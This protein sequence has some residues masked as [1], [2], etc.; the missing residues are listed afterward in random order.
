MSRRE[1]RQFLSRQLLENQRLLGLAGEHP[2]MAPPLRQ[3]VATLQRELEQ[4]PQ[5]EPEARTVLFFGGDPVDGSRGIDAQFAAKVLEPFLE[6]VKTEYAVERHGWV[7]ARGVRRDEAQAR[8]MLTGL[9]RGSFGLE[10]TGPAPG[11]LFAT[12]ELSDVL[13]RITDLLASAAKSDE[14]FAYSLDAVSPRAF[15]KLPTFFK[16]LRDHGASLRLQSGS[17]ECDIPRELVPAALE[18]VASVRADEDEIVER[19]TFRGATLES[20]R[21][22]FRTLDGEVLSGRL[23]PGLE[24]STVVSWPPNAL[25]DARIKV[26]TVTTKGGVPRRRLELLGLQVVSGAEGRPAREATP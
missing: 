16:V 26:T 12:V 19:G 7:G 18:R 8:L 1:N 25:A 4:A 10:L 15:G 5:A 2:L 20:W 17:L 9:P 6:M 22:D 3:R 21:F 23:G 11:D 14:E 24:E 13:V